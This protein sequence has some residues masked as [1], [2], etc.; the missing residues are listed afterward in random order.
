MLSEIMFLPLLIIHI[1]CGLVALVAGLVAMTSRKAGGGLHT[2]AGWYFYLAMSVM[3]VAAAL[4]T[5]WKPDQLNL[6]A[7][8]LTLYLVQTARNAATNRTSN[9]DRTAR[10]LMPVGM[11]A[12]LAFIQGGT[13]AAASANGEFQGTPATGFFVFG[14]VAALGLL[15]DFSLFWRQRLGQRQRLARHLWR[16]VTAYF[17]AATSL[18][19][20]QQDDIFPFLIGSPILLLPS[21]LTLGFLGYWIVR[22]RFA[23]NWL[24]SR[25]VPNARGD[26]FQSR[27]DAL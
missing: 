3:T 9:L 24:A 6:G 1:T 19:L 16:M 27:K 12:T 17:L 23:R 13:L 25:P 18:F 15:F 11:A 26:L 7:A 22:V 2:Q 10:W 20:G 14:G 5:A 8:I 4:L 21:L